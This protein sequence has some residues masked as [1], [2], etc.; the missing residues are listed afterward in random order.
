MR[1]TKMRKSRIDGNQVKPG[2]LKASEWKVN[3]K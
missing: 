2:E 3:E 1:L